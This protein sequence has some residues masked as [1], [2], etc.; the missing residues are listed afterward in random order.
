MWTAND[1]AMF[2]ERM[3]EYWPGSVMAKPALMQLWEEEVSRYPLSV[4][5]KALREIKANEENMRGPTIKR[6]R[7]ECA[8]RFRSTKQE[9]PQIGGGVSWHE[10]C[11]SPQAEEVCQRIEAKGEDASWARKAIEKGKTGHGPEVLWCP[12]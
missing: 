8:E 2:F 11:N 1:K 10:F 4:A 9:I 3:A 5:L 7:E 12:F 6:V